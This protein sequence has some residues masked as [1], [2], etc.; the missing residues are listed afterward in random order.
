M[1]ARIKAKIYIG[2]SGWTY[3][4]WRDIFYPRDINSNEWL[5]FYCQHFKT[6]ELNA[7]F[8]HLLKPS[9]F[10]NWRKKTP[11]DFI[12]SVKISRY[13]THIKKLR[14]IKGSWRRFIESARELKSKLGPILWQMPPFLK[15]DEKALAECLKILPKKYKYAFEFRHQSWFR[16]E[17][18]QLL[19]KYNTALVMADSPRFPLKKEITAD[20]VYI[21]FHGSKDLY[22]S[23][24]T[25]RELK[26]WAKDIKTWRKQ[27]I[28]VYAYFN[29]D[30]E[31]YAI[32]NAGKL[33]EILGYSGVKARE[34]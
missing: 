6:V 26:A 28:S 10:R 20:F 34:S 17:I 15:V 29:N 4:H 32:K 5:D 19:K 8:Y 22:G 23:K 16:P 7:S 14:G 25:D 13:L 30:A 24:Y 3:K 9:V 27:G 31:G 12:F 2:T 1:K 11:S 18:F 33:L 21:R